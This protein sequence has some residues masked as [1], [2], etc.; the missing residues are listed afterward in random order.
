V[1]ASDVESICEKGDCITQCQTN[2]ENAS[3][4]IIAVREV[5]PCYQAAISSSVKTLM[6][7][8]INY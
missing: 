3:M 5:S 4:G 2:N 1:P 8:S 7:I 6:E